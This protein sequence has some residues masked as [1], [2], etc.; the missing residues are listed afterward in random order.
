MQLNGYICLELRTNLKTRS[1]T[2]TFERL[3]NEP[4]LII[5]ID[6]DNLFIKT[7][8]LASVEDI[9]RIERI[10]EGLQ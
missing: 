6:D 7:N 8:K 2:K 10:L 3:V 5:E 9:K 4:G 1:I